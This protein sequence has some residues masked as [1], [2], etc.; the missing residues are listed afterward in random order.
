MSKREESPLPRAVR[1]VLAQLGAASQ[2]MVVAVSGGPDSVALLHALLAL[3]GR[4]G[5]LLVLAHLNHQLRGA[6]S[7]EDEEFVRDLHGRLVAE[8]HRELHFRCERLD[9]GGQAH[10]ENLESVARRV[11]YAWLTRVA[12][13]ACLRFVATGHTADDQAETVLHR[14]LRGTGLRGLRGIALR[15]SLSP[16]VDLIRPLLRTTR[17]EVLAYLDELGQPS[18]QDSSNICLD[19][20]RNKIRHQ[21]LPLLVREYNPA[22]PAVLT[23]LAEEADAAYQIEEAHAAAL[24]AAAE[25]PRAG[26]MLIFDRAALAAAPR[27]QVRAMFRLVWEREHWPADAMSFDAWDRLAGV[28]FGEAPAVDLPGNLRVRARERV[29]QLGPGP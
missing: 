16:G 6:E 25:L 15:R 5:P 1:L 14:L 10:G 9:V 8:G 29:V 19:Y 24:L 13:E 26:T 11:R 18:R 21:L 22:L 20:T 27:H 2:G 4:E 17:A 3:R 23:R 7:D 12:E 28:A